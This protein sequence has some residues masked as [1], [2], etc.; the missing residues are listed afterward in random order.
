[1][2][3]ASVQ[4]PG[5]PSNQVTGAV[6]T[7]PKVKVWLWP[8]VWTALI[9][10]LQGEAESVLALNSNGWDLSPGSVTWPPGTSFHVVVVEPKGCGSGKMRANRG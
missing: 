3:G 5:S 10:R 6:H 2:K 1:M 7:V 9:N 4:G 8:S